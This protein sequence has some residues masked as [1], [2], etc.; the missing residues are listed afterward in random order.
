MINFPFAKAVYRINLIIAIP[1]QDLFYLESEVYRAS[2]CLNSN[3][4][5]KRVKRTDFEHRPAL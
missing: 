2:D 1:F 4:F 3:D 5:L